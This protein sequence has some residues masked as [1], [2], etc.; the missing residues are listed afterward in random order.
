MALTPWP[1]RTATVAL[2]A[3][4]ATLKAALGE[5]DEAVV[6]RLGAVASAVVEAYAPS[7]PQV[8]RDEAVIRVAARLLESSP[9]SVRMESTGDISTSFSPSLTGALLHSGCKSLLYS[10]RAKR[11]GVAK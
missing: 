6:Q 10:F 4:T 7:A 1:A 3:A 8:L 2:A 5:P 11:A 9:V